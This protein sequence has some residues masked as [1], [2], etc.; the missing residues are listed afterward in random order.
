M[1]SGD[2]HGVGVGVGSGSGRS[3]LIITSFSGNLS[4]IPEILVSNER[5]L[6][7]Y[8]EHTPAN[9]IDF[10]KRCIAYYEY[11]PIEIQ[12]DNGT[13]FTWNQ[14]KM[15]VLHPLSK[16]CLELDIDHHKIR[17]RTPRHNGKVERSHRNDNERFYNNL[18]FDSLEDLRNKGKKYLERS[19][20]IPMAVLGY[21]TPLQKRA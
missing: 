2:G 17:P 9:T 6:F 5:F 1:S 18:K 20:K 13:E 3:G 11:K 14:E 4:H 15:K 10:I 19:N 21:K 8:D 12:T 16:L 7:W